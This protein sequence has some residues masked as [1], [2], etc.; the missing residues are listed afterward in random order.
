MLL[1]SLES[2]LRVFQLIGGGN[3]HLTYDEFTEGL[4]E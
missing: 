2:F 1:I 3:G 4:L